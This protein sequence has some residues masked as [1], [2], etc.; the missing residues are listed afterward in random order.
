MPLP[1][2][3]MIWGVFLAGG[4]AMVAVVGHAWQERANRRL[5]DSIYS[6]LHEIGEVYAED[7]GA[8]RV[9]GG[10]RVSVMADDEGREDGDGKPV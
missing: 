2:T 8:E 3:L 4:V 6:R 5:T 10:V 7:E 1:E 9:G